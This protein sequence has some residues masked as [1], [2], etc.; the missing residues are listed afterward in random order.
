MRILLVNPSYYHDIY[1]KA[2]VRVG[3]SPGA[4][5]LGLLCVA[6]SLIENGN[7]AK[8]IDLNIVDEPENHL[9]KELSAFNP[10]IVGITSTTPL[11]KKAYRIAQIVKNFNNNIFIVA[12]GPHPSALPEEVLRESAIDCVVR[13]EGDFI[14]ARIV[15]EGISEHIPNVFF[16]KNGTIIASKIQNETVNDINALPFPAYH[17][18]DLKYYNQPKLTC[19]KNPVGY[20]ETSRG[21]YA[22]CVYCNKNIHGFKMRMKYPERV[23]DEMERMLKLGFKEL[24]IIDDIFTADMKR[25]YVICEEIIKRKL[26]FP[27]YPRG[28]IRVDRVNPELLT[29]MKKAGCYRIPFGIESGSQRIIDIIGKRITLEQA[30]N[31]VKWAKKAGLETECY[32]MMGLPFETEED[33]NKSINFAIKLNP[34]YTKFA[35]TI[36]L[37]GTTMFNSMLDKGQITSREWDKYTFA[38]SP[39]EIYNHDV[40]SWE[41]I[42]KYSDIAYRRFYLRPGYIFKKVLTSIASGT[43]FDN[44][45]A[46]FEINW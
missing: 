19:R 15:S 45:K 27:W 28:G 36:P 16:K 18:L 24:H 42:E 3:V 17:L 13:G 33:L 14:L 10:D 25:A 30:E 44:I 35:I 4:I 1:D 20:L 39:K 38:T 46:F 40:L 22:K 12:G 43:F 34:D 32:F 6:A 29:M 37:P 41:T 2:K 9:K 31:A 5:S 26:K 7:N 11:I 23:V 8:L 21:C